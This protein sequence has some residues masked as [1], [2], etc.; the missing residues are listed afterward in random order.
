MTKAL[1]DLTVL[2]ITDD[3]GMYAGK[4]LADM[5][6]TVILIEPPTG[7][8]ARHVGPFAS[9]SPD[10]NSSLLFWYNNTNKKSVTID[11]E[12][13]TGA[14]I[15]RDLVRS[16]DIVIESTAPGYLESLGL[17]YQQLSDIN[18][19][20]IMTSITP[21][22]QTGPYRN[23]ESSNLVLMAMSG[24]MNSCGY[25]DVLG[26]PPISCDGLQGLSLIHI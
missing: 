5:G 9:N 11:I 7:H 18:P 23:Y 16:V 21:F 20:L 14:G 15:I 26:S 24:I 4:L 25:D 12:S 13:D 6:A 17:G 19:T 2:E 3:K 1:E 22:G 10:L 8:V